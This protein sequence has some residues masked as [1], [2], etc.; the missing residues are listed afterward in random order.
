MFVPILGLWN[1]H[2][3][4]DMLSTLPQKYSA[5]HCCNSFVTLHKY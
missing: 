4:E 2:F 5:L 3:G 1:E